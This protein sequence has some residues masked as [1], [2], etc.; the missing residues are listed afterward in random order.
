MKINPYI[1][2]QQIY[3]TNKVN[4]TTKTSSISRTDEL[5]I[6]SFGRDIQT[7]KAAVADTPDVRT[8]IT[9]PLKS[10]VKNGTYDVSGSSFA[11]KLLQAY[12]GI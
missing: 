1:Q 12:E 8:D 6:S 4:K 2:V 3:N 5:E 7:A 11:E 10:A 9:T